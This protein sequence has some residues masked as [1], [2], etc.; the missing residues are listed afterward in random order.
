M[1]TKIRHFFRNILV[2]R[3]TLWRHRGYDYQGILLALRDALGDMEQTQR[4][5]DRLVNTLKHC[6]RMHTLCLVLD[7]LIEGEY[8]LDK[9]SYKMTR[10]PIGDGSKS[11][12]TIAMTPSYDFPKEKHISK[13]SGMQ[14]KADLEY[15]FTQLNKHLH[16][17]WD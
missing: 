9:A 1:V 5:N 17:F 2:F 14:E 10:T 13:Y 6:D 3:K 7:R 15:L 4:S 8:G 11:E 12:I 16:S